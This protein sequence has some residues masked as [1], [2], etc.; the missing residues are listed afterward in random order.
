M[1]A[2]FNAPA[3]VAVPEM[4][5]K[6][7][8]VVTR[9]LIVETGEFN[10]RLVGAKVL[11]AVPVTVSVCAPMVNAAV[12]I[13]NAPLILTVAGPPMLIGFGVSVVFAE[14]VIVS[15]PPLRVIVLALPNELIVALPAVPFKVPMSRVIP[16]RYADV[17]VGER[18]KVPLPILTMLVAAVAALIAPL[19]V[20]VWLSATSMVVVLPLAGVI[21][22]DSV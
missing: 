15:V 1:F 7:P 17:A 5:T 8:P 18:F 10:T 11:V 9:L 14:V 21:A 4:V 13:E 19:R 3:P 16:P 12:P 22:P 6:A 2:L 20:V